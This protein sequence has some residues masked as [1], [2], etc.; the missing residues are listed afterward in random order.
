MWG[1]IKPVLEW[2]FK[3]KDRADF[4]AVSSQWKVLTETMNTRMTETMKRMDEVEKR[5][6][7]KEKVLEERYQTCIK[8]HK[9]TKAEMSIL[10]DRIT[11]LEKTKRKRGGGQS[12]PLPQP[13]PKPDP[14]ASQA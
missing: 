1:W 9:S 8:E 6:E 13:L 12:A 2:L 5:A 7:E 14:P 3:S 11:E 10:M 4:D